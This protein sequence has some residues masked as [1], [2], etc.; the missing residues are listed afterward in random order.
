MIRLGVVLFV[1]ISGFFYFSIGCVI[2]T[3]VGWCACGL[4]IA[5]LLLKKRKT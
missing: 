2:V 3:L 1:V 4:L 5:E